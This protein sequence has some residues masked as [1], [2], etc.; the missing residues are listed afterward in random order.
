MSGSTVTSGGNT[1][2]YVLGSVTGDNTFVGGVAGVNQSTIEYSYAAGLVTGTGSFTDG[3]A[4]Y[5]SGTLVDAYYDDQTTGQGSG[6][7]ANGSKGVSTAT[8]KAS[9]PTGFSVCI[10]SQTAGHYPTLTNEP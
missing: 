4:G 3:F 8:L 2:T 6:T 5:N 10:W 7:Q 9:L 1:N